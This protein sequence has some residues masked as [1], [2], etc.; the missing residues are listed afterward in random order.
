MFLKKLG[1]GVLTIVS[2]FSL[3]SSVFAMDAFQK[4]IPI[5]I[6][7]NKQSSFTVSKD[8]TANYDRYYTV[9]EPRH[10]AGVSWNVLEGE[11]LLE[12]SIDPEIENRINVMPLAPGYAEVRIGKASGGSTLYRILISE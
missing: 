6:D 2:V 1:L 8:V 3:S 4:V 9:G 11:D 5:T 10:F 7:L 12:F